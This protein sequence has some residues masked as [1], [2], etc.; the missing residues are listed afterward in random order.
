MLIEEEQY[1]L[2]GRVYYK[3]LERKNSQIYSDSRNER[4][5]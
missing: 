4:D 5:V 3:I 1:R 2:S